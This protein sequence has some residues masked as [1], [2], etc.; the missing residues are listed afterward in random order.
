VDVD[1]YDALLLAGGTE[2]PDGLRIDRGAV[3]F[4]ASFVATGKPVA[5]ICHGPWTLIE[6]DV[7]RSKR[8]DPMWT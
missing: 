5:A 3:G 1:E 7:G 4:V 8:A 6:A 2:N